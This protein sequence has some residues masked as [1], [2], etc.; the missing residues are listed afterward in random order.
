M[1]GVKLIVRGTVQGVGYRPFVYR[2]AVEC[3]ITGR[4]FNDAAGVIIEAFGEEP[5]VRE[6]V[7]R[8]TL[9]HPPLAVV[10][11]VER[12]AIAGGAPPD[13]RIVQSRAGDRVEVDAARD[14][15]VCAACLAEMRDPHDRRSGHAFINCTDCGPRYTI[16][17]QL[18][19]DRLSTTMAGFP[20]CPACGGEYASPVDRRFHAQPVCCPH[21][22]PRLRLL[23]GSGRPIDG[24]DPIAACG[25]MLESG[26]IV[27]VK[28]IGGFHL[29]CR[30]D[31]DDAVARLRLLKQR[32]EKPLAI[33]ARDYAAAACYVRISDAERALLESVE[34]PIVILDKRPGGAT[35]AA[36]I[37]PRATTLGVMLPYAPLQ[38]RLF[39]GAAYDALVMTSGNHAD[40][41]ICASNEEALRELAGVADAFLVHNRDIHVRIDDSIVRVMGGHPVI[42]R[43]ARGYVPEPLPA[44]ADVSG[45][46][47]LGGILK[48]TVT[49]G[50][51][52]VC[53][54]SQY[55]GNVDNAET[56]GHL[57]AMTRHLSG[58]LDVTPA[59]YVC[60]NHPGGLARRIAEESGKPVMYVQHH[61]AHAAACAAENRHKGDAI[62]IVFDGTGYGDDGAV[63]GGEILLS[64]RAE[65]KRLGHCAYVPQ[66]GGDAAARNPGR[67]AL[68]I[69][70]ASIGDRAAEACGW[71]PLDERDAVLQMIRSGAGCAATSSMGRLF[72]ACA[73][74]LDVCRTR[75]Y[76][77]QPAI[78]L[79]GIADREERGD[80]GPRTDSRDGMIVIDGPRI[81]L[82][83]WDDARGGTSASRVSAR[84]HATIAKSAL[85]AIRMAADATGC[86]VVCLSGGCF[87]NAMLLSR[88][89]EMLASS[90]F[91]VL[92]H[93]LLP[94]NDECVS[95]GQAIIAAER[96][97]MGNP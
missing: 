54:T 26:A 59:L 6:F 35:L 2:C 45:I 33:M 84:F 7:D 88:L 82:S 30:A 76:E 10:R 37:A 31:R 58:L 70:H 12:A 14:T 4:V 90:G 21:C 89:T 27:A 55:L 71:M 78:E 40:E 48:G 97:R 91:R 65:F 28:G 34:R 39:D 8:I 43:R 44:D 81:L 20:M 18:P 52:S 38:Y 22:G 74:L 24:A 47:A 94:P 67:M 86:D 29:A 87:Q 68:A 73:A 64:G 51:G 9:R 32:E 79:E 85:A 1:V 23:D 83:A 77:G 96:R 53:Y 61:H 66:P 19:Y 75:T 50:R 63:W 11:S 36:Q 92:T 57:E 62:A 41:P 16:I 46:V 25:S 93:R 42:M 80:Y 56:I 13:F 72:D 15:A 5:Q 69:L 60:D 49:V 3:G 17:K 95:F